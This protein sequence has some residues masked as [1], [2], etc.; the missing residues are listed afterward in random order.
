MVEPFALVGIDLLRVVQEGERPDAMAPERPVVEE[1]AGDDERACERA[2][3]RLVGP[4]DEPRL[5][6]PIV[7][8]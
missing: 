6:T 8:E 7:A 4:R 2:A 5:E 3:A 1:D